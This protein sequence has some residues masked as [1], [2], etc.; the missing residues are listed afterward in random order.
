MLPRTAVRHAFNM[1][2]TGCTSAPYFLA[3][4]LIGLYGSIKD[5]INVETISQLIGYLMDRTVTKLIS[6]G[7]LTVGWTK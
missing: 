2:S 4:F 5:Q 6:F 1:Q 3:T 7:V